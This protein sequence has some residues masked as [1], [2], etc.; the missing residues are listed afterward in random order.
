MYL[1]AI[2]RDSI[3]DILFPAGFIMG[4]LDLSWA[5]DLLESFILALSLSQAAFLYCSLFSAS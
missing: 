4:S 3:L 1:M 2:R 5:K